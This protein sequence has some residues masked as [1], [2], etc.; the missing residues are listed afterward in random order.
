MPNVKLFG[1]ENG[2][3]TKIRAE[4]FAAT[5][6]TSFYNDVVVTTHYK[7]HVEDRLGIKKPF[8]LVCSTRPPW[9]WRKIFGDNVSKILELFSQNETLRK[10]DTEVGPPLSAFIPGKKD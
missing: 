1:F 3:A 7:S 2:T 5:N 9:L 4:I 6:K 10:I 8:I